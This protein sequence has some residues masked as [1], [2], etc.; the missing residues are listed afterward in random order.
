MSFAEKCEPAPSPL[1]VKSVKPKKE[2][3]EGRKGKKGMNFIMNILGS[4][5]HV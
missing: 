4:E 2:K 3:K 5:Y 1:N